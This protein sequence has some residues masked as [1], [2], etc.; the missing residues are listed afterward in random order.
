M[1]RKNSSIRVHRTSKDHHPPPHPVAENRS[2]AVA[3]TGVVSPLPATAALTERPTSS[4]Q[5]AAA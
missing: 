1:N 5:S 3:I 2:P 4:A